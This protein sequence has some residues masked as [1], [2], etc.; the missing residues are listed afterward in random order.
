MLFVNI[1]ILMYKP[2]MSF[3]NIL[4]LIFVLLTPF[5]KMKFVSGTYIKIEISITSQFRSMCQLLTSEKKTPESDHINNILI[6]SSHLLM[7]HNLSKTDNL[8]PFQVLKFI[9]LNMTLG[10]HYFSGSVLKKI[11]LYINYNFTNVSYTL[12]V[13]FISEFNI[14]I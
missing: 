9:S 6:L 13:C 12:T 10:R 11:K 3:V 4:I 2:L 1:P 5:I 7:R 14:I 8:Y